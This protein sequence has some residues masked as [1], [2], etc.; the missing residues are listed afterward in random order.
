MYKE[1]H[2]QHFFESSALLLTFVVMGKLM[3]SYAKGRTSEA[4]SKLLKLQ[5]RSALIIEGCSVVRVPDASGN[6]GRPGAPDALSVRVVGGQEKMVDIDLLQCNDIAKVLPGSTIPA[7]GVVIKGQSTVDESMMTGE[8]MPVGKS[9]GMI[10]YGSTINHAGTL[11]IRIS[12]VGNDTALAQIVRVVQEAQT[13]KAPI[14]KIADKVSGIFAPVVLLLSAMTFF[15]WLIVLSL[16]L[17]PQAWVSQET[18]MEGSNNFVFSFLFAIA[19]LVI[20]C[21]CALGLATPTAVMV[22]SGVGASNGILI[23]GGHAL[24]MAHRITTVVFD[25]TGTLTKGKLNV[26]EA[27][28]MYPDKLPKSSYHRNKRDET[29]VFLALVASAEMG[30]EHPL[31]TAVVAYAKG[32]LQN[33]NAHDSAVKIQEPIT[34]DIEPGLGLK[35]AVTVPDGQHGCTV[36]LGNR[37]WMS[38]LAISIPHDAE[39]EMIKFENNGCTAIAVAVDGSFVGIL[40]LLDTIKDDAKNSISALAR[41]GIDVHMITGDNKRTASIVAENLGIPIAN[42]QAEVLPEH[43]SRAVKQ[44]QDTGQVVAMV[45][46]GIND[47]PALAQ[48]DV[49]IAVGQGSEIAI[50][51]ADI[52]LVND[53][54]EGVVVA[55]HLSRHV[56]KRILLNFAWALGYNMLGIPLAAGLFYPFLHIGLPPKFAGLA[57]AFSSVSVVCSSLHLKYYKKPVIEHLNIDGQTTS[58]KTCFRR[59]F[60]GLTKSGYETLSTFDDGYAYSDD[61]ELMQMI[62]EDDLFGYS[63]SG[64]SGPDLDGADGLEL[65]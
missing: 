15:G 32:E 42:V 27:C 26:V 17:A 44:L 28:C 48:A 54:M 16:D 61:D 12:R 64:S 7:D 49:G 23:K 63:T 36:C 58:R 59:L 46:D 9:A 37:A 51:A 25:K 50:E 10:V 57:M 62:E 20:A 13:S 35:A 40:G 18:G 47:S 34:V 3:E 5:P 14:E 21:P 43:K 41:M 22:G 29:N 30:S 53:K 8:S 60:D 19:V 24:E 45:G 1:F 11:Y 38:T 4:L 31:A 55:I 6:E 33:G 52:V 2:G 65:V 39:D 56:F